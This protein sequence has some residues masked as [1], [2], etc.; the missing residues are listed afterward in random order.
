MKHKKIIY[1]AAAVIL[2]LTGVLSGVRI[3]SLNQQFPNPAVIEHAMQEEIDGGS[4]S[5]TVVDSILADSA[6]I[7]KAV[8]D[9][10]DTT[11][12]PDGTQVSDSQI[13]TLLVTIELNNRSDE[14]QEMSLVQMYAESLIWA[15]GIDGGL[16]PL[17][18]EDS[19]DPMG[20]QLA[21][22]EKKRVVLPYTLYDLQFQQADWKTI[23]QRNFRLTLSFYPQKHVVN[24]T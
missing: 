8:P 4:I 20:L 13:R 2:M 22:H 24:L 18:N 9:Y 14:E 5:L 7:K 23:D 6:Y 21:P 17:F 15:N 11:E 1:T 12:N 16:Y 3:Y 10:T 19:A